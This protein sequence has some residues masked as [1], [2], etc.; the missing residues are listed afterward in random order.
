MDENIFQ[1]DYTDPIPAVLR[2]AAS[3][4]L[5]VWLLILITLGLIAMPVIRIWR[6]VAGVPG[7]RRM[8]PQARHELR[9][10]ASGSASGA[11]TTGGGR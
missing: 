3:A 8:E 11:A 6:L 10:V 2:L 9:N 4:F 7:R 5:V 1:Q